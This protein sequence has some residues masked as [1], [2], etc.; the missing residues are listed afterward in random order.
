MTSLDQAPVQLAAALAAGLS[1][2]TVRY[3][4]PT[5][6]N[7]ARAVCLQPADDF[8]TRTEDFGGEWVVNYELLVTVKTVADVSAMNKTLHELLRDVLRTVPA[9][10]DVQTVGSPDLIKF[11][12][13]LRY[14]VVVTASNIATV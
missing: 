6:L 14:G 1:K 7:A 5:Q 3:P 13:W 11:G 12:D 2:T 9:E 10:W 8:L 4:L